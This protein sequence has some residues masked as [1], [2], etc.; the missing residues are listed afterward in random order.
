MATH[1]LGDCS[2]GAFATER[3]QGAGDMW[4][5]VGAEKEV[6]AETPTV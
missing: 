6:A 1:P 5:G 2:E 4:L 3:D